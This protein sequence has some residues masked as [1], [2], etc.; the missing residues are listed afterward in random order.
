MKT[1]LGFVFFFLFLKSFC[2]IKTRI[3]WCWCHGYKANSMIIALWCDN[4]S[5]VLWHAFKLG[6]EW[7]WPGVAVDRPQSVGLCHG[8]PSGDGL[9]KIWELQRAEDV[10]AAMWWGVSGMSCRR[11]GPHIVFWAGAALQSYSTEQNRYE[12]D[13]TSCLGERRLW[14]KEACQSMLP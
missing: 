12:Y 10:L 8:V 13:T 2:C 4:S 1:N 3:L 14:K 9:A 6:G 11:V 7:K 5:P